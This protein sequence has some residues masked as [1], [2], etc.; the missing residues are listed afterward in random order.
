MNHTVKKTF[1]STE[2]FAGK[3]IV[4]TGAGSGMQTCWMSKAGAKHVISLELSH[5]L[6]GVMRKNLDG[7]K[8]VDIVQCSIDCPPIKEG[9]IDGLVTC[10]N[11]IQHT[12]SVEK[13]AHALWQI[14]G[15]GG[16]FVFNCYPRNDKG[17][18]RKIWFES[19][20]FLRSIS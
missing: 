2:F 10:N 18:I 20:K 9:S 11:A 8:N 15:K 4:D 13:T 17:L 14:V 3:L 5:S 7:L 6:D 19:N 1:E 16:E 12:P